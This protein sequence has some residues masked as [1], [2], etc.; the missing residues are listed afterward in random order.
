MSG[1]IKRDI[2][3][4]LSSLKMDAEWRVPAEPPR[5][6]RRHRRALAIAVIVCI[7]L[8]A[9]A[10]A[11]YAVQSYREAF[12][13]RFI[14]TEDM[15]VIDA[16]AEE[17]GPEIFFTG[18]ESGNSNEQYISINKLV[19]YYNEDSVR[20]EAIRSIRPL[21]NS[22]EQQV[23]AAADFALNILEKRFD[24]VDLHHLYD[25]TIVFALFNGYSDYGSYNTLWVIENGELQPWISHHEPQM[26]IQ[27]I[28]VSP[29]ARSFAVSLASN[30]SAYIE[31]V[32]WE[33]KSVSPEL[34]DSARIQVAK[35]QNYEMT[36]RVDYEN[37][38]GFDNLSW[39]DEN[40]LAFT[41][42]LPFNNQEIVVAT[43]VTYEVSTRT[44][45]C[46]ILE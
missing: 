11:V 46:Q 9:S 21:L 44:L 14:S 31:V 19:E 36:L 17:Y 23:A 27:D 8:L 20:E 24:H 4:R 15:A 30:K 32:D 16:A 13:L 41:G 22:E 25:G 5:P 43:A 42:Q 33:N 12:Y 29:D 1:K 35:E 7:C 6:V 28:L 10:S 39:L 40:T 45:S 37:Y 26:Y 2:D 18:L 38:A 34:I 3:G